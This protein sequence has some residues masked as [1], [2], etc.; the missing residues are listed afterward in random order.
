MKTSANTYHFTK[1]RYVSSFYFLLIHFEYFVTYS[2][3][4]YNF[5]IY[6]RIS[7]LE[8]VDDF[9]QRMNLRG[10]VQMTLDVLLHR[11]SYGHQQR[12]NHSV[13]L[14]AWILVESLLGHLRHYMKAAQMN[15]VKRKIQ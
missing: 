14:Q 5:I 11:N 7:V 4:T 6:F 2:F 13:Q 9:A 3:P 15:L 10:T 12:Q 1:P 8:M